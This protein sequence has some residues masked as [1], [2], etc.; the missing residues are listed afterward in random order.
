MGIMYSV[1]MPTE[2]K[3]DNS[4][5]TKSVDWRAAAF[6]RCQSRGCDTSN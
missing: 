3:W 1:G 6:A 4:V 2:Y 5:N